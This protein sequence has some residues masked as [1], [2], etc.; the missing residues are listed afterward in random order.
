MIGG[1]EVVV[2]GEN[3]LGAFL[4]ETLDDAIEF[5]RGEFQ[6]NVL[7]SSFDRFHQDL[8]PFRLGSVKRSLFGQR[9][10]RPN[11]GSLD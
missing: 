6:I 3:D 9:P 10:V 11:D 5:A 2:V 7:E 8:E 1:S 4:S